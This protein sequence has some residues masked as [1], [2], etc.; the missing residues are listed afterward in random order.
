MQYLL[1]LQVRRYCLLALQSRTRVHFVSPLAGLYWHCNS[2]SSWFPA[3]LLPAAWAGHSPTR[4]L[5]PRHFLS[6]SHPSLINWT[7]PA[8]SP[9]EDGTDQL[10]CKQ[11]RMAASLLAIISARPRPFGP[12]CNQNYFALE[13]RLALRRSIS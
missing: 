12:G 2:S 5:S 1:T 3:A 13:N 11:I 9:H 6:V 7:R 10:V 4:C 8:N